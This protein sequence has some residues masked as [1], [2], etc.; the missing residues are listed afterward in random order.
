VVHLVERAA[1]CEKDPCPVYGPPPANA[2]YIIET[3]A[4][5]IQK[6]KLATG[7]ELKFTLKL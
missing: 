2:R 1:P 5:F 7:I 4:G 6:E 3:E